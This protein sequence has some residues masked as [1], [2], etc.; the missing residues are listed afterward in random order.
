MKDKSNSSGSTVLIVHKNKQKHENKNLQI[1]ILARDALTERKTRSVL[2]IL[3]VLAG[4]GVM[5]ALNVMSAGNTAF[6]NK[7]LNSLAPNIMF[8]ISG[9]HGFH[10][11]T[12]PPTIII[13]SQIV[14]RIKSVP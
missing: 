1:F 7:Q 3:M 4:G 9:Q 2:T 11:T 13:N 14:N 8:V 6:I 10:G 12:G 5:V